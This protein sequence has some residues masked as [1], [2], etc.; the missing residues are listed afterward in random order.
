VSNGRLELDELELLELFELPGVVDEPGFAVTLTLM[1]L[2]A[3]DV[4]PVEPLVFG[5][6]VAPVDGL[7]EPLEPEVDGF[8]AFG[9]LADVDGAVDD[10][11]DPEVVAPETLEP[12]PWPA[13]AVT[14]GQLVAAESAPAVPS[15]IAAAPNTTPALANKMERSGACMCFV[16]SWTGPVRVIACARRPRCVPVPASML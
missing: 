3:P 2:P 15:C 8:V 4:V 5:G 16:L 7:V 9:L 6:V 10:E 11:F 12:D 14:A 13:L 1:P